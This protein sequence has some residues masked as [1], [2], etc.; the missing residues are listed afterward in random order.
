MS[1][2]E[3]KKQWEIESI[4]E[5]TPE[6]TA[7]FANL[8]R[9]II[10]KVNGGNKLEKILPSLLRGK[11]D[12]TLMYA[13]F[14]ASVGL[15]T[16]PDVI[17]DKSEM[18]RRR[19]SWVV[20]F[21][22][23]TQDA[24]ITYPS[25]GIFNMVL[26]L[27]FSMNLEKLITDVTDEE[28][29]TFFSKPGYKK[30]FSYWQV[31][32]V[33]SRLVFLLA[34]HRSPP[35]N[36]SEDYAHIANLLEDISMEDSIPSLPHLRQLLY[37]RLVK[38][39]LEKFVVKPEKKKYNKMKIDDKAEI[40][41]FL[42][43]LDKE[44]EGYKDA[45]T[46]FGYFHEI[47][48]ALNPLEFVQSMLYRGT[49]RYFSDSQHPGAHVV[50]PLIMPD[51]NCGIILIQV[52]GVDDNILADGEWPKEHEKAKIESLQKDGF[53]KDRFPT[54]I[55]RKY[56]RLC[57]IEGVFKFDQATR[58]TFQ[59][60]RVDRV[61]TGRDINHC[62]RVII[63]LNPSKEQ[64]I[65]HFRDKFGPLLA[66]Q[67]TG[68]L[69]SLLQPVESAFIVKAL[70]TASKDWCG[71]LFRYEAHLDDPPTAKYGE[72][73]NP[74]YLGNM[75]DDD[76]EIGYDINFLTNKFKNRPKNFY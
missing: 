5:W 38:S 23:D 49:A 66:I 1:E 39:V 74:S 50:L 42:T 32:E 60:Q 22:V 19:M 15:Y 14:A 51:G 70:L 45:L 35:K 11:F 18:I 53:E 7:A 20:S 46:T 33:L 41:S 6:A 16:F 75:H 21:N 24:Q 67:T 28:I 27:L 55:V 62:I 72:P 76:E 26:S 65:R 36:R 4:S 43:A 68:D 59:N 3:C 48:D 69:P 64:G 73:Y 29:F 58:M 2:A 47:R 44:C 17:M 54:A 34:H 61:R 71:R 30:Q 13:L 8:V 56:M 10:E 52:K 25:E 57:T 63:N 12:S 9:M 40:A 37:P 31:T